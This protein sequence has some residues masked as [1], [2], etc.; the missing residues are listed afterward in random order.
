MLRLGSLNTRLALPPGWQP[1]HGLVVLLHGFGAPGDDLVQL[2]DYMDVPPTVG[3]AFPEAPLVL[4]GAYGNARAWWMIDLSR[5]EQAATPG[6][7]PDRMNEI[8][9]GLAT[10]REAVLGMLDALKAHTG[11]ADDRVVLG[12]FSQGAMLSLDVVLQSDRGFAGVVLM[13][14]TLIASSLWAPRM[15]ARAG[16]PVMMSHGTSDPLLPFAVAETLRDQLRA[17]GLDVAWVPFNAGHTI[18]PAVLK[19]ASA[20]IVKALP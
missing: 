3:F 2:A 7:L 16:L 15:A 6:S 12:G 20:L 9:D 13:S 5:F 11:V 10:A 17:A 8:P 1:A 4:G 14:G 18:P 19:A